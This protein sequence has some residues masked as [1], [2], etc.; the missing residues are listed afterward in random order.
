MKGRILPA[1]A[2]QYS[3]KKFTPDFGSWNLKQDREFNTGAGINQWTYTQIQSAG[4]DTLIRDLGDFITELRTSYASTIREPAKSPQILTL[5]ST[6]P[7]YL[8]A[9]LDK[10]MAD[11]R[12]NRVKT[13][14]VMLPDKRQTLFDCIKY[15]ADVKYGIHT[16]CINA[17]KMQNHI[18]KSWYVATIAQKLNTKGG[19]VNHRLPKAELS[20]LLP[21]PTMIVGIDVTKPF[22]KGQANAATSIIGVVASKNTDYAQYPASVRRQE[23]PQNIPFDLTEMATERLKC[24]KKAN[25]GALPDRILIY[26]NG[27]TESHTAAIANELKGIEDA[28]E[29]MYSGTRFPKTT[30]I[31]VSKSHHTRFYPADNQAADGQSGNPNVGTVVDRVLTK[32]VPWDFY[33]QSHPGTRKSGTVCPTRYVV[34]KDDMGLG[35]DGVQRLVSF[36]HMRVYP[37]FQNEA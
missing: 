8:F 6:F 10:F 4:K 1:P 29:A 9:T 31:T 28:I 20:A 25:N 26:R 22:P 15:L 12:R 34:V 13:L 23:N 17:A 7:E 27:A 24:W 30:I 18:K 16:I 11:I 5:S 37:C 35:A 33:L 14:L 32:Q 3:K 19:G 36:P 2:V 21:T